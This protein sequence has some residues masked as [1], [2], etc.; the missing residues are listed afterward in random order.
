MWDASIL[1][2]D[3]MIRG[4]ERF[5]ELGSEI[6]WGIADGIAGAWL[7]FRIWLF[8]LFDDLIDSLKSILG[9]GSPSKVFAAIGGQLAAGLA[10]GIAGGIELPVNAAVNMG[11]MTANAGMGGMNEHHH[12]NLTI[13]TSAPSESMVAD[14]S[15]MRAL[16]GA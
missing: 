10:A 14:F 1:V 6:V 15:L 12:Y 7:D 5:K 9:I 8:E 3:E 16:A 11:A 2:L 4:A 13:N